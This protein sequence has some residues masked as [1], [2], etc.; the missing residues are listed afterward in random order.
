MSIALELD[1]GG[2]KAGRVCARDYRRGNNCPLILRTTS[3]DLMVANVFGILRL[4]RPSLW[5]RPL[6]A[7]AYKTRRFR[8]VAMTDTRVSF[9]ERIPP[10]AARRNIEGRTEVDV[11]IRFS[12]V[13][14]FIEAKYTAPLS[15]G[16][17]HDPHRDQLVRLIDVAYEATQRQLWRTEPYVLC[18]GLEH[19]EPELVRRYRDPKKLADKLSLE[20]GRSAVPA[21]LAARVGYASWPSLA[22]ILRE[23]T[24]RSTKAERPFLEE[25]GK[26]IS[27]RVEVGHQ[28]LAQRRAAHDD[29][30]TTTATTLPAKKSDRGA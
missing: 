18:I 30:T 14:L 9:W 22:A 20:L 29:R 11:M 17:T 10:P 1:A 6:L 21:V 23:S 16:T 12:K 4:M 13:T 28:L 7:G 15:S 8:S 5:L 19:D 25:L 26:Y 3:E 2:R 24:G 27:Q